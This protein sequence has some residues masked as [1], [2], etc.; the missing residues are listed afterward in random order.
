HQT[1]LTLAQMPLDPTLKAQN[2]TIKNYPSGH[3]IYLNDASRTALKSD[4]ANFYD[5]ILANRTALQRVLK[6]QART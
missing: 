5:G 1:E 6:M 2:L 4:L 3:M